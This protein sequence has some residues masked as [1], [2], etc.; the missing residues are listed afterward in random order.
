MNPNFITEIPLSAALTPWSHRL[1]PMGLG[2][3]R[4]FMGIIA[5][6]KSVSLI[7]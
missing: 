3:I 5:L 1:Y 6:L 7:G 2:V 4:G